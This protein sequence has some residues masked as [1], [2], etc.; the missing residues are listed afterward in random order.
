[1]LSHRTVFNDYIIPATMET[2]VEQVRLFN[3]ASRGTIVLNA[4]SIHGDFREQAF[5]D[6]LHS[7]QRRVDRYAANGTAAATEITDHTK[8]GV[9]IAGGFG[10]ILY[11][12]STMTWLQEPTA[13]GIE[14]ASRNFSEALLLDQINTA[15]RAAVA[16][17]GAQGDATVAGTATDKLTYD[18]INL[19]HA[20]FGAASTTILAD[21][22]TGAQYHRFVSQNLAN[23]PSVLFEA[24]NVTVVSILGKAVVVVDADPLTD[25]DGVNRVL[26]LTSGAVVVSDSGDIITNVETSNG[27]QRIETTF[28]ADYT[29][30]LALKGYSWDTVT[31]GK[32]PSD[33]ALATGANWDKIAASIKSTAGVMA[34]G[35]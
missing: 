33:A 3:A 25:E 30:N 4:D 7:A 17:I 2:F 8:A 5:F 1:M 29:F 15:L 31:G 10:P 12:P 21:I 9:K 35:L 14:L 18:T 26:G 27:K 11:E 32:S 6:A 13:R 19:A 28:Q 23:A 16:A 20:K 34:I 22:M 24:G